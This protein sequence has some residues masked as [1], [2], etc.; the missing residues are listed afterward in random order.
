MQFNY[1]DIHSHLNLK[2]L[3]EK[4]AD[5]LARM[6]EEGIGTI[7]VGTD[8]ETSKLA[9]ELAEEN[10]DILWA[11]IGL[12]PND[13]ANEVFDYEK[14]LELA[15]NKKV[16]AIGETGLDYFR[17]KDENKKPKPE[18]LN[19]KQ[20]QNSN[21][22]NTKEKQK[23]LFKKHIELAVEV[24]KPLMIHARA[25]KGTQ[26]AYEDVLDILELYKILDTGFNIHAHFHF[27]AGDLTI[28]KRIVE[29]GW[30]MSFDGPITFAREYDE[31][32][33][34][35]P[36]ENMMAETDAPF[37]APVPYRGKVCEPWMVTE[38]YK[39]I[40]EIK[41]IPLETVQKQ[42]LE[43]IKRILNKMRYIGN[44]LVWQKKLK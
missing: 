29:C 6:G 9:I 35:V 15:R 36:L 32:I 40:A 27:F 8:Y 10:P 19:S 43:N 22:Q 25:S 34:F 17:L 7:T 39:K 37:A 31:V 14:Y 24:A 26:D 28:A 5:V 42:F 1:F 38:V 44:T 23:E 30:T 20:I 41:G 33:R 4:R 2:P 3:Y 18:T 11:T 12:H 13:N 21:V 16:V